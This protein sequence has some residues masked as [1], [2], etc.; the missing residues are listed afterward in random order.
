MAT[1][2]S[3]DLVTTTS[4]LDPTQTY[5]F[6][7]LLERAKP[8]LYYSKWADEKNLPSK[9]GKS[10]IMRRYAHLPLAQ[11]P[12]AEGVPPAGRTPTLLDY[13]A[14]LS[15]FGDFIAL[16]DFAEMTGI[17]DYQTHWAGLLG[18]QYGMTIDAVDRDVVT[19]G[20]S[21]R[22]QTS[23]SRVAQN[24]IFTAPT[25]DLMIRDLK[26][27]GAEKMLG[28]NAGTTT[29][30]T[31]PILPAYPCVTTPD[32]M[33]TIQGFT[34][35]RSAQ[36]YRGGAEGEVGRYK[37]LAFFEAPDVASTFVSAADHAG[38]AAASTG[39]G[40][41]GGKIFYSLGATGVTTTMKN[42]DGTNADVY[43]I[44][45][46]GKHGFTTVPLSAGNS[47]MIRKGFGSAGTGD[48]LDQV[49]SMGWKNTSARLITN[50]LWIVRAEATAAI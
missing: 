31:V 34:G 6:R 19:A 45:A 11:T 7:E 48:P 40:A 44:T 5:Y 17:D 3:T 49:M 29:V 36:E 1:T 14:A 35:Y 37:D 30:G 13:T 27:N 10:I 15:Q 50:Q 38:L 9:S 39:V 33:Y 32:V 22:Y 8:K 46:F 16:T 12:L 4:G 26:N 24:A 41:A 18:E 20:T 21:K 28:G 23:T 43:T 47:K 42:I 25:L 2:K